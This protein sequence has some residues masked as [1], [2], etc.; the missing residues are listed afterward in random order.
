MKQEILRREDVKVAPTFEAECIV[1]GKPIVLWYN[2]GELDG[3]DCCGYSYSLES[4]R[5]DYVVRRPA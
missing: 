2:G 3:T 1:C 5:I 4:D